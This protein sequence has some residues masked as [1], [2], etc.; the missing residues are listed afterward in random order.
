MGSVMQ[1]VISLMVIKNNVGDRLDPC[2]IPFSWE[3]VSE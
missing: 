2:G 1:F 3:N